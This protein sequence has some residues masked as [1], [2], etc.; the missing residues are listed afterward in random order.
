MKSLR[1]PGFLCWRAKL[2]RL[3]YPPHRCTGEALPESQVSNPRPYPMT[4]C[5]SGLLRLFLLLVM[6]L[7]AMGAEKD[8]NSYIL[9]PNDV[10]SLAVYQEADLSVQVRIL[11][12][13]EASFPLIGSVR[14]GGLSV[15]A[16]SAQLH[17]L[18]AKDYLVD[19]KL[20]LSVSDYATEFISVIGAVTRPG[21]IPMPVSGRLDLAA[22]MATAG[23][24]AENADA[25]NIQLVRASGASSAF[26]MD[27]IQGAAGR[28]QLASG[29]RIIVNQSAFVGKSVTVL[30]QVRKPGPVPFPIKG[31]LDLVNA[32]AFAG[33]LTE[34]ANSKKVSINRKGTVTVVNFKVISQRGD[35]PLLLQPEDVITVAERLF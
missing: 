11:K 25:D 27:A 33:G 1:L 24:L 18:Y 19:P 32:I 15:S 35:R 9:R 8:D 16:A 7:A 26:S 12:T 13:G 28:T 31:K 29:D 3:I 6:S 22:A 30:G 21:Q 2:K 5:F 17:E 14:V 4:M 34:L 20:T 23:G 10:I